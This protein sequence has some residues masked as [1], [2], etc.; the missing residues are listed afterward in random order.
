M[1]AITLMTEPRIA[2]EH[3]IDKDWWRGAVIW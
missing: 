2:E 1:T 3:A